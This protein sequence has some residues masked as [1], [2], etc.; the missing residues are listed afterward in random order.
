MKELPLKTAYRAS[1]APLA[2]LK[3]RERKS[4]S[5]RMG[6]GVRISCRSRC[7]Q[8]VWSASPYTFRKSRAGRRLLVRVLR[9]PHKGGK[10]RTAPLSWVDVSF[11]H[12]FVVASGGGARGA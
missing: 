1:V 12:R 10:S 4:L 8:F 3:F 11:D 7:R 2:A 5:G 9:G 6:A